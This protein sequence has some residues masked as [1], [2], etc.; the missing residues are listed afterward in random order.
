[1]TEGDSVLYEAD[2]P[3]TEKPTCPNCSKPMVN[4]G[5]KWADIHDFNQGMAM[6]KI[7]VYRQKY[8]CGSC[9]KYAVQPMP[10]VS[11]RHLMTERLIEY[12]EK[13][14]SDSTFSKLAYRLGLDPKTVRLVFEET[15][16]ERIAK[17][18]IETPEVMGI[19]SVKLGNQY[20][21]VIVNIK[22]GTIVEML[23]GH[24]V[25]SVSTYFE[26]LSDADRAKV[27]CVTMDP[28]N[29]FKKAARKYLDK[30]CIIVLDKFH[31]I[32]MAQAGMEAVRKHLWKSA[33]KRKRGILNEG[34][35]LLKSYVEKLT[36]MQRNRLS[37]IFEVFP[38]AE[39]AHKS[40]CAYREI[41]K[42]S[43][44][45]DAE[46]RLD[47][48]LGSLSGE[49]LKFYKRTAKI[50]KGWKDEVLAYFEMKET[51]AQTEIMNRKIRDLFNAAKG[52]PFGRL[53]SKVLL[54]HGV[55]MGPRKFRKP[56]LPKVP[57]IC[58][59]VPFSPGTIGKDAGFEN[60]RK[61]QANPESDSDYFSRDDQMWLEKI[62]PPRVSRSQEGDED[63]SILFESLDRE[64]EMSS[65][66]EE[67]QMELE[68][69]HDF[70][71]DPEIVARELESEWIICGTE[72]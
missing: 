12:I 13:N 49:T 58:A 22:K 37:E 26:G 70:G 38:E 15:A 30:K 19:D 53:R 50:I 4:N 11:E 25:S 31:A 16:Q 39:D 27:V 36:P 59:S 23:E 29:A 64:M 62:V 68:S 48:W 18:A 17:I 54:C 28:W 45:K 9:K 67:E 41:W 56:Q 3:S 60:N 40:L 35:V 47:E 51:N 61:T 72:E 10:L 8:L 63:Y 69:V 55:E 1:M 5:T 24:D 21:T 65:F 44:R 42:A 34:H 57:K 7:R 52:L 46:A 14:A 71:V 43:D 66:P 32:A 2:L 33:P 6:V 20:V